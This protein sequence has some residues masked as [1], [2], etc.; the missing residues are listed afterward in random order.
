[1][2]I[3]KK[4]IQEFTTS[5]KDLTD[6]E[7]TSRITLSTVEVESMH[8][9]ASALEQI[10][11]G[12][13]ESVSAHPNADKLRMC[14]V[15]VG[16]Q[17]VQIVCGGVNVAQG[18]KVAVALPGAWV[19]WHG[20]GELVEIRKTKLRGEESGGMICSSNE[21]GLSPTEGDHEI[22]DLS[23][24]DAKPGTPLAQA[25]ELDDVIFDIEH[26][27]LT[28]RP[29]LMG[30]YGMAREVAALTKSKLT[31]YVP[32]KI[33]AGKGMDLK[34]KIED[35]DACPRYMAVAMEGVV[36]GE[37]PQWMK[38]RLEACGVRSI[39]NVV[40][41]TNYVMLELGQ[42]MHAFDADVLGNR[43]EVR[44]AKPKEKITALD[45][46]T[47]QLDPDM[48][49]I[50]NG[51]RAMAIAGVMGGE[52]SGVS[53]KTT[54]IVFES[55][56]F[57]PVCVRKTSMKL[58]LRSESSAR[59]EKSLDP[60]LC[61][62]A[63]RR[64]V[65]LTTQL[66]PGVR[67]A[68]KVADVY[69]HPPK[70]TTVSLTSD[71]VNTRLGTRIPVEDMKGIL[72]RL[73]FNVKEKKG[74]LAVTI[75]SWRATKDVSMVEDVIEEIARIWGYDKIKSALPDFSIT[76]PSPDVVRELAGS[77]RH[78]LAVGLGST[79]VYRYAF[80]APGILET[81]GFTI[82]DHLKLANP[83]AED[84]PYLC[85]SLVPNLFDTVAINHRSFAVVNVFE[86][87]RVFLGSSKGDEDGQ[88]G[89]LPLQPYHLGLA[90]SAQG[91]ESP[92]LELR[93]TVEATLIQAG[94]KVAF[95]E[96][97]KTVGWM[98]P[99]RAAEIVIG[100]KKYGIL[101]EVA[102]EVGA[103]LGIDRRVA[104]AEIN[105]SVL[106]QIHAEKP[107]FVPLPLFPD[108]KRD[109]AFTV[110]DRT[111]AATIERAVRMSSSVLVEYD[112]F[113]V[114][115]GKGVDAGQKSMA[116]HLTFRSS[117]KTLEAT[118]VDVEIEKISRM[119]KKE[120]GATMRS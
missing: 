53:A 39:N 120:F 6:T 40:D 25:L 68:S 82:D 45:A 18:M 64:A 32:K 117:D 114:Y 72:S 106:A 14:V 108:A 96:M 2:L 77:V 29:D 7:L 92:F 58:A 94:F 93:R 100:G 119:L 115:T 66:C 44:R 102:P 16:D 85:Q 21:I 118:E 35:Q 37:S 26:K 17:K 98:H 81:L 76:P 57:S 97:E 23:D 99:A 112:L 89:F 50:T 22:R 48:L 60:E 69:P 38:Q 30:H 109:L 88:G 67:V 87:S 54:R 8:D 105:L 49:L 61:E 5:S 84:R 47:Y 65:E 56:N 3:S 55:A 12:V 36:V 52:G 78:T 43:I 80:L 1:M 75:P 70:S 41:V 20:E 101:A 74:T 83:L 28:N 15:E 104:I 13:I 24:I 46:K 62:L 116:V 63:L 91:D 31:A 95:Q 34:V 71:L 4:W 19:K 107:R 27:S 79:E 33:S 10:V 111:P 73:G 86:I 11:I 103:R 90:Y 59:F 110:A 9:Q 113:D 42:P 51:E